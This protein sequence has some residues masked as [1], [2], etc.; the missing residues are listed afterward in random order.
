MEFQGRILKPVRL[1]SLLIDSSVKLRVQDAANSDCCSENMLSKIR[2][3]RG[4]SVYLVLNSLLTK[5][6]ASV[7]HSKGWFSTSV[8]ISAGPVESG[9]YAL[10]PH[11]L[12]FVL[13]LIP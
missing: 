2:E 12:P 11:E 9:I 4:S 5:P 10:A 13:W 3:L 7:Q 6:I 8:C 1:S